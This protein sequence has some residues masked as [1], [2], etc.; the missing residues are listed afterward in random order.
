MMDPE[1]GTYPMIRLENLRKEYDNVVAVK[2]LSL[3][4]EKG[5]IY[6]LIGPNG[7]GKTTTLKMITGLLEPTHGSVFINNTN[8]NDNP[9]VVRQMIGYMP[10]F[11]SL[12]GD[13]KTWE[14]LD[15]FAEA[16]KIKNKKEKI[17]EILSLTNLE[18]KRDEF[19]DGLS[20][21]MKQRLAFGKAL[22]HDPEL[23]V[24]DEPASGLDPK[25]RVELRDIIK[26]LS[27]QGKTTII[28][29]HIL[30]ELSDICNVVGIMEKGVLIESGYINDILSRIQT[31]K[32][33]RLDIVGD[34]T[35]V[36]NLLKTISGVDYVNE[37][38]NI[39]EIGFS[40]KREDI[41]LLHKTLVEKGVSVVSF[42]EHTKNLEEIFM[43]IS[44]KEVS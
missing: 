19:I 2:N 21:G 44:S 39:I 12:Y 26:K 15:F 32:I 24:L 6:G 37:K 40:G 16:Y 10:D 35:P 41:P 17:T 22:L 29:S 38:D 36:I 1:S 18:I 9:L 23:L 25:A 14:Y 5:Q 7:A 20:R 33:L 43:S 42:Y 27:S 13:L 3:T 28:S 11:F 34:R 31:K 8:I 4:I 30:T